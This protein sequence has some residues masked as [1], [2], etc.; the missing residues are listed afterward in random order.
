MGCEE[1]F[2]KLAAPLESPRHSI[3]LSGEIQKSR[4]DAGGTRGD[5]KGDGCGALGCG[6]LTAV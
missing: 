1:S 5:G 2:Q 4:R 3:Y 6:L